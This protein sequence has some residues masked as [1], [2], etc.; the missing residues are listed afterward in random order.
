MKTARKKI[1]QNLLGVS[2][3]LWL[4]SPVAP[5]HAAAV[6]AAGADT[7][8]GLYDALLANMR[9]GPVLGARG[10]FASIE[11]VVQDR[12]RYA[13]HGAARGWPG[14]GTPRRTTAPAGI[15]SV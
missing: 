3:V 6:N 11:P 8:R 2:L 7:V 1:A 12:F 4:G 13:I 9:S 10:R 15:G 14:M 5:L